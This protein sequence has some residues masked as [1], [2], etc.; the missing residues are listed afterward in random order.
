MRRGNNNKNSGTDTLRAG[1]RTSPRRVRVSTVQALMATLMLV[2]LLGSGQAMAEG[3]YSLSKGSVS[4][5]GGYAQIEDGVAPMDASG[6]RGG[7]GSPYRLSLRSRG[8]TAGVANDPLPSSRL[9]EAI[10][11]YHQE[12]GGGFGYGLNLGLGMETRTQGKHAASVGTS[13]AY[14]TD[15]SLGP[16]FDAGRFGSQ[17]RLGVRK[18]LG[19]EES[20]LGY[21]YGQRLREIGRPASYMSL[22][23]RMRLKNQ[24]ELSLS[25]YYDD[26]SLDSAGDW[27]ADRLEFD[28][29]SREPISSV[30]GV[31]M[32]LTF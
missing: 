5:G 20:A 17:F 27:L 16:T 4:L 7:S 3:R 21:D 18:P 14:F 25:L 1:L 19:H 13:T 2:L 32:G 12:V 26:Y 29:A 30:F 22:D 9:F 11:G 28:G 10:G 24:S 6:V 15:F 23:G 8:D 31:E